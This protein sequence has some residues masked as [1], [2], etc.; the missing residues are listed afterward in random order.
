M[1]LR[2]ILKGHMY[3]HTYIAPF[4][5]LLKCNSVREALHTYSIN[6]KEISHT[7]CSTCMPGMKYDYAC[8]AA[9]AVGRLMALPPFE[10][11]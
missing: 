2:N 7:L 6:E 4:D 10:C 9:S 3:I 8:L 1:H 11:E 5:K